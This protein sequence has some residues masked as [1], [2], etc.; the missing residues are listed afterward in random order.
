MT[1]DLPKIVGFIKEIEQL[2]NVERQVYTSGGRPESVAEHTW[3]LGMAIWLLQGELGIDFDL[4][5]ALK[6]ALVHDLVEIYAGDTF[7]FDEAGQAEKHER[8]RLAADRL[9][10]Q[11]PRELAAELLGLWEEYE[12]RASAEA[13]VVKAVDQLMPV[14]Q[15]ILSEGSGWRKHNLTYDQILSKKKR[16]LENLGGIDVI[17]RITEELM[18]EAKLRNFC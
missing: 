17:W 14:I 3:H 2:K 15:N 18:A 11:L 16:Y 8:E 1:G 10:S 4:G 6:I 9:C 12:R 7:F 5:R 13:K